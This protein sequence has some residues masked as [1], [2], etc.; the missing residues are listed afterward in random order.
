VT[1]SPE[2]SMNVVCKHGDAVRS[3]LLEEVVV[4]AAV[5]AR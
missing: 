3:N 5:V 2:Q 4:E 1:A